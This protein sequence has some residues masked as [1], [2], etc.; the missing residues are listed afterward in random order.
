[1]LRSTWQEEA[2][3]LTEV[4]QIG[5]TGIIMYTALPTFV[6]SCKSLV[7]IRLSVR[8]LLASVSPHLA[9]LTWIS[10]LQDPDRERLPVAEDWKINFETRTPDTRGNGFHQMWLEQT[11]LFF[12]PLYSPLS[13]TCFT[14][15]L[16]SYD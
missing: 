7:D 3:V 15:T 5:R 14:Y 10:V 9:S 13:S 16:L 12:V 1:M 6:F 8:R 4:S 2:E 11:N